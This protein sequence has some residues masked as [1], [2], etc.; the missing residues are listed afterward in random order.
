VRRSATAEST[1]GQKKNQNSRQTERSLSE[2]FDM[3]SHEYRRRTLVALDEQNPRE[4]DDF[5]TDSIATESD[6]DLFKQKM[7]HTHLPKLEKAGFIDWDRDLG[8]ITRGPRFDEIAPLIE[9]M[10][11]HHEE[12]PDDWP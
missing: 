5:E 7:Y 8:T 10:N 12:L 1:N 6:L 3:L 11:R 4:E 2:Q 9:L